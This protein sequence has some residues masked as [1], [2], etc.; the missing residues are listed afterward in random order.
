MEGFFNTNR[1]ND[2]VGPDLVTGTITFGAGE[3]MAGVVTDMREIGAHLGI[4]RLQSG[5]TV[6]AFA[7]PGANIA[8]ARNILFPRNAVAV[9]AASTQTQS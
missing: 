2:Q 9:P 3:E 5:A 8:A 1:L 6:V 4:L 7:C